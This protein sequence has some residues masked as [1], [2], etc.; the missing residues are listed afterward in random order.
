MYSNSHVILSITIKL[1]FNI[2]CLKHDCHNDNE[3]KITTKIRVLTMVLRHMPI[4]D[5]GT[6]FWRNNVKFP[7][8]C[9]FIQQNTIGHM[10]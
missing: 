4:Q 3:D 8:Y 5:N 6:S 7:L 2:N 10:Y 9:S 1:L